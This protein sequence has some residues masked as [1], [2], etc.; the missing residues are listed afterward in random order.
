MLTQSMCEAKAQPEKSIRTLSY[1][2][3]NLGQRNNVARMAK[4]NCEIN[5][6]PV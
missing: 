2:V 3:I 4:M 1:G 6:A 5:A